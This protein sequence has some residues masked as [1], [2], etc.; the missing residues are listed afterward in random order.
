MI[1]QDAA[2]CCKSTTIFFDSSCT[3]SPCMSRTYL[4]SKLRIAQWSFFSVQVIRYQGCIWEGRIGAKD[5]GPERMASEVL[6]KWWQVTIRALPW[7]HGWTRAKRYRKTLRIFSNPNRFSKAHCEWRHES[8]HALHKRIELQ[9]CLAWMNWENCFVFA[10]GLT[11]HQM[12]QVTQVNRTKK[13]RTYIN[14]V[15][16]FASMLLIVFA[17]KPFGQPPLQQQIMFSPRS[18]FTWPVHMLHSHQLFGLRC[19]VMGKRIYC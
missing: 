19:Q 17:S 6:G 10:S 3:T 16:C 11:W 7:L 18:L 15:T 4:S 1:W 2:K 9:G 14:D 13:P 12:T 5:L 8:P